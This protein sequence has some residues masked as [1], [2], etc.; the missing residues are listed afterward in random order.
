MAQVFG[1]V[2]PHLGPWPRDFWPMG[3]SGPTFFLLSHHLGNVM[4][5]T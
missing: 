5:Q 1:G 2:Q 4:K 3:I